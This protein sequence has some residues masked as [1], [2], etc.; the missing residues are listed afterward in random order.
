MCH[1][2]D[3]FRFLVTRATWWDEAAIMVVRMSGGLTLISLEHPGFNLLGENAEFVA[4][5]A[6]TV[7]ALS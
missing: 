5:T 7:S 2:A 4:G 1:L 3:P 6:F